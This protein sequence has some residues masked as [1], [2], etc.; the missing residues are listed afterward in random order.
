[1]EEEVTTV[2]RQ[3]MQHLEVEIWLSNLSCNEI[4]VNE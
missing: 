4:Q 1:M 3:Q 2:S